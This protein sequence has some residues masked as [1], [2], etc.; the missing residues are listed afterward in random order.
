MTD[1]L[2][3]RRF[4]KRGGKDF[5]DDQPSITVAQLRLLGVIK[6]PYGSQ[7]MLSVGVEKGAQQTPLLARAETIT[8]ISVPGVLGGT[9]PMFVCPKCGNRAFK[10]YYANSAYNGSAVY[11][12]FGC[13]GF[14]K[15]CLG[16]V[17]KAAHI[18]PKKR[19][20]RRAQKIVQKMKAR[21]GRP[22]IECYMKPDPAAPSG[23]R[24]YL[25]SK[26]NPVDRPGVGR[27]PRYTGYPDY[28]LIPGEATTAMETIMAYE[29]GIFAAFHRGEAKAARPRQPVGR[30]AG[31][32]KQPLTKGPDSA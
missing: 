5:Y 11:T 3:D 2:T 8:V 19:A 14:H 18:G 17:Y 6:K 32:R 7:L 4:G 13:R 28:K 22:S 24:Y 15:E 16:L 9:H 31:K 21:T 29:E 30:P 27:E 23:V 20:L 25:K 26:S 10:L 12:G 1:R